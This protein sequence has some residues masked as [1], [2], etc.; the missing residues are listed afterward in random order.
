MDTNNK[1]VYELRI[2]V[3]IIKDIP[4]PEILA[5]E[6]EYIDSALA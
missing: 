5:K 2:K 6:A 3:Y 4:L 1:K